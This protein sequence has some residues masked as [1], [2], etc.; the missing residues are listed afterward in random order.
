MWGSWQIEHHNKLCQT[1]LG[2]HRKSNKIRSLKSI[3]AFIYVKTWYV[4]PNTNPTANPTEK[5]ITRGQSY[6][7][8]KDNDN[9]EKE[10]GKED[11]VSSLPS[12]KASQRDVVALAT[13]LHLRLLICDLSSCSMAKQLKE[14]QTQIQTMPKYMTIEIVVV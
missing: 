6:N 7:S 5:G 3:Q 8:I 11:D 9:D 10:D 1:V 12:R 4:K 2:T 14:T 13:F